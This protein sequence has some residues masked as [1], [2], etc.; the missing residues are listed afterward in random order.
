MF[1]GNDD[2][3]TIVVNQVNHPIKA[4]FVRLLPVEWHNH[5]S[6][7]IEIYGCPGIFHVVKNWIIVKCNSRDLIGLAAIVI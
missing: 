1:D 7:R 5:I 6:M 2:S 3:D 4:R